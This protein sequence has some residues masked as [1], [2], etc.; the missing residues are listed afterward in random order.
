ML[1]PRRLEAASGTARP[2]E[3]RPVLPTRLYGM[4]LEPLPADKSM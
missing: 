4:P 1:C 2:P 3:G